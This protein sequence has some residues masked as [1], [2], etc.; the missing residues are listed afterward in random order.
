MYTEA[1]KRSPEDAR[2]YTNRAA[3]YT[4][5]L[6]LSEALKD[7]ETAIK[8]DP[9]FGARRPRSRNDCACDNP[10][11]QG[12]HQEIA[13]SLCHE[14]PPLARCRRPQLTLRRSTTKR[15]RLSARCVG[16]SAVRGRQRAD[17]Q[18]KEADVDKKNAKEIDQQERKCF[19][20]QFG[21]Q[22]NETDEQRLQRAMRDPEVQQ[23]IADPAMQSVRL[24]S[25]LTL[26]KTD[27]TSQ[28]L[29]QAQENPGAL[30]QHMQNPM[31][32]QKIMKCVASASPS[33][34]HADLSRTDS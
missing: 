15:S 32:R 25:S 26:T 11:S 22:T 34:W 27:R 31:I 8:V 19:E 18:A 3:A 17:L 33:D 2:G 30:A 12:L 13:R 23:I 6:A 7:A 14:G 4:K 5:L 20:A 10:H 29:Q 24:T 28:I 9:K 1:I 21:Q 16:R